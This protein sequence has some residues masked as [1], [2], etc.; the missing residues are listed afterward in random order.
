VAKVLVIDDKAEEFRAA[1]GLLLEEHSVLYAVDAQEGLALIDGQED[2]ECV[3]LDIIMPPK[4]GRVAEEEGIACLREIRKRRPDLPVIMLTSVTEPGDMIRAIRMGAF[5][6]IIKPPDEDQLHTLI[7]AAIANRELRRKV[8]SLEETVRIRDE[9]ETAPSRASSFGGLVGASPAMRL[10]YG[11]IA[12]LARSD[13]SVLILGE[14]GTGKELVAREVHAR[15]LRSSGRFV[16]VNCANLSGTLLESELFGH[17][18]G[19][20]TDARD[21][22]EGAFRAAHGGTIFLDEIAEMSAELQAKLL[23]VLQEK[24]IKPLGAD[25]EEPVDVRVIA[26]T[27]QDIDSLVREGR[28]RRDLFYRLNVV[29]IL[30]PP[31][32]E[33]RE[34]VPALT[35]HFLRKHG[36]GR[37]LF[38]SNEALKALQER[39]WAGNNVR[40]LENAV[41]R[42]VALADGPELSAEDFAWDEEGAARDTGRYDDL[43]RAVR[44][45]HT[46][47][48]IGRFADLYGKLALAEMM[49]R[50]AEETGTD[51]EAGRLLGFIPEND[52][53]DR[54]YNN[55]R[56]WK[57]R[58]RELREE[59]QGAE[60]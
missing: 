19:A 53:G 48:D 24:T 22:R 43:W 5:H 49:R 59:R 3:L 26:A 11:R 41:L 6:Y 18:R 56:S 20:F 55:F 34:D 38:L 51:R 16:P 23:R 14:S 9:M 47:R 27:H 52:P 4:L 31:L 17:K 37:G 50:A 33:R 39:S 21:D 8:A 44:R 57:R 30:L 58:L 7:S 35:E 45:G 40:E 60:A 54:A 46:P 42:A 12:K 28:F 13:V 29:R 36:A 2:I 25:A 10:V 1:L 32:R 15:G